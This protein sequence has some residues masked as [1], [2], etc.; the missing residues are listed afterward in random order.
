M[1][2]GLHLNERRPVGNLCTRGTRATHSYGG[3]SS[4]SGNDSDG[5]LHQQNSPA[6]GSLPDHIRSSASPGTPDASDVFPVQTQQLGGYLVGRRLAGKADGNERIARLVKA[7]DTVHEAREALSFGRGNVSTDLDAT[8]G[9]SAQRV[10]AGRVLTNRLREGGARLGVSHTVAVAELV[11]AGLCSEHGDVSVHRHVPKLEPGDQ[12]HKVAAP[13]ADH[14]WAEWRRPG[15]PLK[16]AI[17]MDAWAEGPAVFA[18]DGKYTNSEVP[19]EARVSRYAYGTA[20]GRRALSS[21][22]RAKEQLS[23]VTAHFDRAR[24]SLAEAGYAPERE[25]VWQPEPVISSSFAEQVKQACADDDRI[26]EVHDAALTV[27]RQLGSQESAVAY[28]AALLLQRAA[29]LD[30]TPQNPLRP[31]V[32]PSYDR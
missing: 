29:D 16:N 3:H 8:N 2:N 1:F 15:S 17:V 25:R 10:A 11:K 30:G 31:D 19:D 24:E 22:E 12:V 21:V 26:L 18:E 6:S 23:S 32:A 5:E 13:D 9:E 4:R 28:N 27:A 20:L 7:N 14:G